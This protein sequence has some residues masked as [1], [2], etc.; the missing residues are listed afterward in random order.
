METLRT[1]RFELINVPAR[2]Q[3]RDELRIA[4]SPATRLR[5][6]ATFEALDQ[7]AW[8]GAIRGKCRRSC[9]RGAS[10]RGGIVKE[11]GDNDYHDEF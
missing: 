1:L 8:L 11:E 2:P 7:D 5:Y 10:S 9:P 4:A 6:E 3:G